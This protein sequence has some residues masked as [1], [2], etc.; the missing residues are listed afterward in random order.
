MQLQK[1][2]LMSLLVVAVAAGA[3]VAQL[4]AAN[5]DYKNS[6]DG[7]PQVKAVFDVSQGSAFTSNLVFWAVRNVYQDNTV[8]GLSKPPQVAVVF[9]GPVVRLLSTDKKHYKRQ[10]Q[11]EVAKFQ[12][13]L[14]QMK[15]DG[16]KLEVCQ[17]ALKVLKVDPKTVIPEI[18][19][20]GNGFVSIVGYQAQGYQVVR[21]P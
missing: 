9:H 3:Q 2:L 7:V 4:S 17:Y 15:V 11:G 8:K 14:R 20:V 21:I 10:N 19:Q 12:A 5:A 18:D 1:T 13:M 16:V 6:L